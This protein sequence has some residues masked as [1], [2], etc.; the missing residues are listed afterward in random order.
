MPL[1]TLFAVAATFLTT[2][3]AAAAVTYSALVV[4][5]VQGVT[6]ADAADGW[7]VAGTAAPG[8]VTV[9][10]TREGQPSVTVTLRPPAGSGLAPGHY[11]TLPEADETNAAVEVTLPFV[12]TTPTGE[13]DVTSV[14]YGG[15]G[16]LLSIS[17]AYTLTCLA[18]STV[19]GEVRYAA[20]DP[21]RVA[22]VTG[23]GAYGTVATGAQQV[24][25]FT[26]TAAGAPLTIGAA[27][28]TGSP[29][30]AVTRDAC[31]GTLQPGQSCE[32]DVRFTAASGPQSGELRVPADTRRGA[33][34]VPL[35]GTGVPPPATP[36]G[37]GAIPGSDG[38]GLVWS[39]IPAADQV[40]LRVVRDGTTLA[41]GIPSW[42][43]VYYDRPLPVGATHTYSLVAVSAYGE[44][45]PTEALT[46]STPTDAPVPGSHRAISTE[47]DGDHF[48]LPDHMRPDKA[49]SGPELRVYPQGPAGFLLSRD[50]LGPSASFAA[51][52]GA[53]LV[54]GE[55]AVP[56]EAKVGLDCPLP[57]TEGTLTVHESSLRADGTPDVFAATYEGSCAA[58]RVRVEAR[59]NS[60]RDYDALVVQPNRADLTPEVRLGLSGPPV[61]F[62]ITN[63]GS[64]SRT[65]A[66]ATAGGPAA[67]DWTFD[68]SACT[69][70]PLAP[71]DSCVITGT[72]TPKG[73]GR[74][75]ASLLV[76]GREIG[77]RAHGISAPG[78]PVVS[79]LPVLGR[80]RLSWPA[81]DTGGPP[82]IQ[83]Y[84]ILRGN[85]FLATTTGTFYDVRLDTLPR[86]S[87]LTFRVKAIGYGGEGALSAP[88]TV[89]RPDRQ[90]MFVDPDVIALGLPQSPAQRILGSQQGVIEP[91]VSPDGSRFAYV[92]RT[93]T[94]DHLWT[95]R[96][97]LYGAPAAL[98]WG[99][100]ED[101]Q[102]AWSPDGTMLA[103]TRDD[104]SGFGVRVRWMAGTDTKVYTVAGGASSP[105]WLPSGRELVVSR[106]GPVRYLEVVSLDGTRRRIPG[107]DGAVQSA[108][109]P[110]GTRIAMLVLGSGL[111]STIKVVPIGGGTPVTVA[112]LG[113]FAQNPTWSPDG[114]QIYF[115]SAPVLDAE[116]LGNADLYVTDP[117]AGGPR[118]LTNTP[119]RNET[120]PVMATTAAPARAFQPRMAADFTGDGRAEP[121][122]FRQADGTWYIRG[123]API[124]WGQLGDVPVP[125]DYNG[126]RRADLAVYRPSNG[127]WYVRGVGTFS[128][129]QPGDVPAPADYTGDRRTDIAVFRPWNGTWYTRSGLAWQHG[130]AGDVPVPADYNGDGKADVAVFRP[131]T[132]SWYVRNIATYT[133]GSLSGLPAP[134]DYDGDRKADVAIVNGLGGV[135]VLSGRPGVTFGGVGDIPVP[136]DFNGDRKA[137]LAVFRPSTGTW[138]VRGVATVPYGKRGDEPV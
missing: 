125:G 129:G 80:V 118:N 87:P 127:G 99:A 113:G 69:A 54:P 23:S 68:S 31:G 102:P 12:C 106:H 123:L 137:D 28:T 48:D 119:G 43:T 47:Y 40:T 45:A 120:H 8:A 103:F 10:A 56:G 18:G 41:E 36:G 88:V 9:T 19:H 64:L 97:D 11:A 20:P 79:A 53:P 122:V 73:T 132:G 1:A 33:A 105:T 29:A 81:V 95:G 27:V 92:V 117:V 4:D 75:D 111:S 138:Y 26:V 67:A 16:G 6:I 37:F 101:R 77:L 57:G 34:V 25:T 82:S 5:T 84:M 126:D 112:S 49:A 58:G 134:A 128:F 124:R 72:F 93:P 2:V 39:P 98:T 13:L 32:V 116:M 133:Y 100:T 71:G 86:S 66:T 44:S 70:G 50:G 130:Q 3:P 94:G 114:R 46:V 109:S 76:G 52:P 65:L 38:V 104:A 121:A 136:G 89:A 15:D 85:S 30:F 42:P 135:W 61:T 17:A 14:E 91:A 21:Y 60:S 24:R 96:T 55:Y 22:R 131:T 108:V 62:T 51:A 63:G 78:T 115:D 110:D 59:W 83:Y 90:L 74:R 35:S 107:T 7:S